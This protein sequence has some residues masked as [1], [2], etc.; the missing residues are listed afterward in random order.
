MFDVFAILLIGITVVPIVGICIYSSGSKK[1]YR[2][3]AHSYLT[4]K[5]DTITSYKVEQKHS[6]LRGRFTW[7]TIESS[8]DDYS[9]GSIYGKLEDA[10][11]YI[12][13]L[14]FDEKE[15]IKIS[16]VICEH[17]TNRDVKFEV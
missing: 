5:G 11:Q 13:S 7:W 17:A 12:K 8:G 1:C 15:S 10:D 14:L 2:V 4:M 6:I 9:C 16:N 3:V